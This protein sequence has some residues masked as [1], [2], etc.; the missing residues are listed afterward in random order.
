MVSTIKC[1]AL[2]AFTHFAAGYGMVHGDPDSS[3]DK[4]KNPEVPEDVVEYLVDSGKIEAPDVVAPSAAFAMKHLQFGNYLITGPGVEPDT[5]IKGKKDAEA[6]LA[7]LQEQHTERA[8]QDG[9]PI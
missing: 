6:F 5:I 3:D 4:A 9:A 7:L 2:A 8:E 1:V